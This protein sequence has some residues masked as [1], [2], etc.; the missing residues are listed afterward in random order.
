[1]LAWCG[2]EGYAVWRGDPAA[3]PSAAKAAPLRHIELATDG[4]LDQA[5]LVRTLALPGDATLAGLDLQ[6]LRARVLASGQVSM[7]TIVRQ[8]PATLAV[9]ITER[10]PV[11]RIRIQQGDVPPRDY[12]VARDGVI[13]I[14]VGFDPAMVESL[15]WLAGVKPAPQGGGFAP[16]A[17]ME[18]VAS[19][20]AR[21]KLEA[22]PLY[23]TWQ[24]VSLS[25]LQ[26]DGEIEVRTR[27]GLRVTFGTQEDFF[28]QLARLDLLLDT[29]PPG[30]SSINL[31][32]GKKVPVSFASPGAA[33]VPASFSVFSSQANP[34]QRE[35]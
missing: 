32:L 30:I 22:E 19:L 7:A 21:A 20:L 3:L 31:A 9:D 25:A 26:S 23:R 24:T 16:I 27:A 33:P 8:F 17:D 1:M 5:W 13:F 14:G 18:T 28:P 29:G 11:A 4:V 2:W 10:Q 6:R 34:T 12:L 15:P 35:F